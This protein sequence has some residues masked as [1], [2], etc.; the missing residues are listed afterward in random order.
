MPY[1]FLYLSPPILRS[2]LS[3]SCSATA[4]IF[5]PSS[6]A[7]LGVQDAAAIAKPPTTIIKAAH[8]FTRKKI[9]NPL[10]NSIEP[11]LPSSDFPF[12]FIRGGVFVLLLFPSVG[13]C[14]YNSRGFF[15]KKKRFPA[16]TPRTAGDDVHF[17]PRAFSSL[18]RTS[19]LLAMK[20][21]MH[22]VASAAKA[23]AQK[24]I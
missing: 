19:R 11:G 1:H 23:I 24:M 6:S 5:N 16:G 17:A 13:G 7:F 12:F 15:R 2:E 21:A 10:P 14:F 18:W 8:N 9:D 4:T 20:R 22:A 3:S